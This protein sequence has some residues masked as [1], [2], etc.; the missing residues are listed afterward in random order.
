[1]RLAWPAFALG[2]ATLLG[3]L[4]RALLLSLLRR[5]ANGWSFVPQAIRVPSILWSIV[6]GLWAGNEVAR[7]TETL[8]QRLSQQV[9][10]LLEVAVIVSV[11]VTV[12]NVTAGAGCTRANPVLDFT[13]SATG[14]ART[15]R[16]EAAVTAVSWVID[17]EQFQ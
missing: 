4:L 6:L 2:V 10:M 16:A 15:L 12:S 5:W 17:W 13:V 1:M 11:T 3:L 8:P 7:Q 14:T 9:G